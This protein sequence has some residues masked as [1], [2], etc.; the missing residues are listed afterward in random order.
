MHGYYWLHNACT[1]ISQL[2]S[3]MC[4]RRH[5]PISVA[6]LYTRGLVLNLFLCGGHVSRDDNTPGGG[7]WYS[8]DKIGIV[9]VPRIPSIHHP[10]MVNQW[11]LLNN[12]KLFSIA[13][14]GGNH[15]GVEFA[16]ARK[17]ASTSE[18]K[19]WNKKMGWAFSRDVVGLKQ[20]LVQSFM[21]SYPH[22]FPW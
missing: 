10:S 1:A 7:R 8:V 18:T 3:P 14:L 17:T 16:C 20:K 19:C 9:D 22:P 2:S 15:L 11:P 13:N 12:V 6:Q 4:R 21:I 5:Q